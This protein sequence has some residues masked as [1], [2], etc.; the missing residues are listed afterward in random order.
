MKTIG[1]QISERCVMPGSAENPSPYGGLS[2]IRS[3][4]PL[5]GLGGV[6]PLQKTPNLGRAPP[7]MAKSGQKRPKVAK[8]G[9][10]TPNDVAKPLVTEMLLPD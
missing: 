2:L 3:F 1:P 9:Q 4:L 8:S 5:A 6:W 7:T 10:V